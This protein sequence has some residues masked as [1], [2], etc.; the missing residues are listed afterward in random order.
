MNFASLF[1]PKALLWVQGRKNWRTRYRNS[2]QK[3]SKVC[4]MHVSSLGEFEQGR[5]VI[6]AF[7]QKNP[8][9]QIVLT[10]FSPSGYE[11]R[12]N[13]A[14]A[15]F[16][17]YLPADSRS[18][19]I[20]FINIIQPDLVFWVKY[21]FWFYFLTQLKSKNIPTYLIAAKF[22]PEQPFF[23]WYGGY[24]FTM[25]QCFEHIFVQERSS[26][27]L[28]QSIGLH[29]VTQAGDTRIDRVLSIAADLKENEIVANFC[30]RNQNVNTQVFVVG[31]SW[32]EDENIYLPVLQKPEFQHFRNIIAPHEPTEKY[33]N[34]FIKKQPNT[35]IYSKTTNQL[36]NHS[37]I[38]IDNIGMLNTLYHYGTI[39]YIGGGFG[40]GIHNTLEPAAYGLPII[41]GPKYQKFEEAKQLIAYGGAFS[42]KNQAELEDILIKLQDHWFYEKSSLACKKWLNENKG[43]TY[44]ILK[45]LASF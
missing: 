5:P 16:V 8:E 18:N 35:L 23:K 44:K 14:Y 4:W 17:A 20:D 15:D 25:L 43:A 32:P 33:V 10:F 31:S 40:K 24:W 13:Y 11:L 26:L 45:T 22:R 38:I 7:Q 37:T 42:I 1:H 9:W 27:D 30:K 21:D 28:L 29:D 3:R 12:K 34:E 19:A 6:E 39:A 36:T 41:F 2:F